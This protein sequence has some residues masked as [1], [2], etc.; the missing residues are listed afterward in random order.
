MYGYFRPHKPELRVREFE[1]YQAVY[2]GLC[3]EL[4][5]KYGFCARFM[6]NYDAASFIILLQDGKEGDRLTQRRCPANPLRKRPSLECGRLS[7]FFAAA[8][9]ILFYNK[10]LDDIRD[11]GFW[12]RLRARMLRLVCARAFKRAADELPDFAGLVQSEL[13][14]LTAIE[15]QNGPGDHA[16]DCFAN[17]VA[18]FAAVS[19]EPDMARI[20]AQLL[21][22]VGRAIYYIDALDDFEKDASAGLYNPLVTFELENEAARRA[23]YDTIGNSIAAA[24]AAEA[25]LPR[26]GEGAGLRVN[27]I[28][29]GLPAALERVIN[30]GENRRKTVGS[31]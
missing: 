2:C 27:L 30:G 28:S 29:L 13:D 7:G 5:K 3:H 26:E 17:I 24:E 8:S 16:A 22:H 4:S 20:Y 1:R 21:Y 18:G 23:A 31:I 11:G 14:R 6:V 25:L 19:A 9:V 12:E 10:L 15:S